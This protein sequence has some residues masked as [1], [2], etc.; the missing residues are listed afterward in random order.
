LGQALPEI[1]VNQNS[2]AELTLDHLNVGVYL[3]QVTYPTSVRYFKINK[4]R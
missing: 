3:L 4:S 1:Q 2:K